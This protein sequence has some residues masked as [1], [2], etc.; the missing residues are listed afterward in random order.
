MAIDLRREQEATLARAPYDYSPMT[1]VFT[2]SMDLVA[3]RETTTAKAKML[4]VL[5]GIPYNAWERQE[6][7]LLGS[8]DRQTVEGC[9]R[10]IRWAR[11]ARD[12][13]NLHLEVLTERMRQQGEP[14]PWF[15]VQ[16]MRF[17]AELFYILFA[18]TLAAA[19]MRRAFQFNAEFEDHAEHAYAQFAADHP[20]WDDE[21]ATGP[22]VRRYSASTGTELQTWGDVVRRIALDER[23]HM[24][25]SFVAAGKPDQVVEY[26]GMPEPAVDPCR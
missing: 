13:E 9:R 25:R 21:P 16:P 10:L 23:D 20:E 14:D 2:A 19:D 12:N 8:R 15:L 7:A 26:E 5:A 4:E 11:E 18:N 24:N 1:R 22:A 6:Q 3:G 17:G